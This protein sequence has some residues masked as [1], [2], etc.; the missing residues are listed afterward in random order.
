[1]QGHPVSLH[2]VVKGDDLS[3]GITQARVGPNHNLG[4]LVPIAVQV[5]IGPGNPRAP[6]LDDSRDQEVLELPALLA[7]S[8]HMPAET[9]G[10]DRLGRGPAAAWKGSAAPAG[11][12]S[13]DDRTAADINWNSPKFRTSWGRAAAW[14]QR[15][16]PIRLGVVAIFWQ[17]GEKHFLSGI[18]PRRDQCLGVI[19]VLHP[20]WTLVIGPVP[21]NNMDER[22][23]ISPWL[24]LNRLP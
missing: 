10:S 6:C 11:V 5:G 24:R 4:V 3:L 21:G 14:L 18:Q 7:A 1:M 17:G 12:L 20:D 16:N 19:E 2:P 15:D 13:A 9:V 22:V 8:P 23:P